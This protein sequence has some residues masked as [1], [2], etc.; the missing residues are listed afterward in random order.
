MTNTRYGGARVAVRR[1]RAIHRLLSPEGTLM[2]LKLKRLPHPVLTA[3]QL[4]T[5][6]RGTLDQS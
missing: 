2:S 5:A 6:F 4:R 1:R 3:E